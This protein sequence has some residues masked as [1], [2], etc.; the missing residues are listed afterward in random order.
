MSIDLGLLVLRL[1][2]GLVVAAHGAQKLFGWFGG[3]GLKG[4]GGWMTSLGL[5]PAGLWSTLGGLGEF[6]GGLLLALGLLNP[7]GSL[8]IIGAMST[9]IVLAHWSKGFWSS[10]GGFEF[11]LVL[12]L[13]GATLGLVGPGAYSLDAQLGI[14]L[15]GWL[16]WVGLAVAALVVVY[17]VALTQRKVAV[18]QQAAS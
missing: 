11:P 10:K 18:N 4:F 5:K 15:P 12:L 9:A 13:S 16:F 8:G 14:S 2:I 3:P 1:V 6:G 7:L 17:A